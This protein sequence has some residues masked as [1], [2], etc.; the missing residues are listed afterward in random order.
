MRMACKTFERLV[1]EENVRVLKSLP[2]DLR[3]KAETVTI[4]IADRPT[5]QE[6][7]PADEDDLLGLYEGVSLTDR[8]VGDMEAV[9]DQIT[10]FRV[11]LLDLCETAKELREE[12][13]ITLL[14][15]LG[16]YFGFEEDELLK[17]GL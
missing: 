14:H 8:H 2:A 10:L 16:H 15:E 11:P 1:R 17:R 9:A 12:I 6:S 4:I 7:G 13:R 3:V 5:R